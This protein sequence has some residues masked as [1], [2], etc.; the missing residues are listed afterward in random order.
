MHN[1]AYEF[2]HRLFYSKIDKMRKVA[3]ILIITISIAGMVS[4]DEIL[5]TI[6]APTT[7]QGI[8]TSEIV[9]GLKTALRVGTDSSVAKTSRIN[10]YYKDEAIKILLPPEASVIYDNKSNI[11][12]RT[13][14]VDRKIEDAILALN[15][16]AEDAASEAGPIFRDAI[17]DLSITDGLSILKG[18]NPAGSSSSSFDSTA[19][20]NYL[21]STTYGKLR[22]AFSPKVNASLNKKL[23][24]NY[25]PNQVWQTLTTTYN[26]VAKKS[27]GI[28][29]PI[30]NTDLGAW[31]TE[32]AL[33]GLF[34]KVGR[35]E[36]D[37]RKDP[38]A[39][40]K[41]SVGGI[42]EKVFGRQ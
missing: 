7:G 37:I 22:D 3:V 18:R 34:F 11:L 25:S 42:L 14:G 19:A 1:L 30:E 8:T 13:L 32:R 39:W 38:L 5:K 12:F 9:E 27:M 17:L 36:I 20:T 6:A 21:R 33:D 16:A 41:T 24:G 26:G 4:C 31:V 23:L 2:F 35:E 40:A 29:D 10:G 28:I 15:R